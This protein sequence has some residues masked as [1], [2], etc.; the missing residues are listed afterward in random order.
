MRARI[1][2]GRLANLSRKTGVEP[3]AIAK[4]TAKRAIRAA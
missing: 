3:P 1:D 2:T 4:S